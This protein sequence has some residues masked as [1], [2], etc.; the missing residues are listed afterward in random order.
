MLPMD[1]LTIPVDWSHLQTLKGAQ[2]WYVPAKVLPE[3]IDA[4]VTIDNGI[5]P[6][7]L[8]KVATAY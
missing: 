5:S 7:P 1:C 6:L 3:Q 8:F 2:Y 4:S